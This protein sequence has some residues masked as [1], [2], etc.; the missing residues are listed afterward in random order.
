VPYARPIS[1]PT[2]RTSLTR[3]VVLSKRI[4][5]CRSTY[6]NRRKI[7]AIPGQ[8]VY[9]SGRHGVV[10]MRVLTID[11]CYIWSTGAKWQNRKGYM[12]Y[13]DLQ[14]LTKRTGQW[15]AKPLK[16]RPRMGW[17]NHNNRLWREGWIGHAIDMDEFCLTCAEA[18]WSRMRIAR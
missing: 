7:Q 2:D 14:P 3:P 4:A 17:R 5:A 15:R 9:V 11:D 10:P 8:I 12:I 1:I 6:R 16:M 13:Y 18:N